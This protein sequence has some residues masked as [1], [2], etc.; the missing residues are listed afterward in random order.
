V[1]DLMVDL[2]TL[3]SKYGAVITQ[4]GACYFDRATG[5]IG[6]KFQVNIDAEDSVKEGFLIESGAVKFW[7]DQKHRTWLNP[8][9]VSLKDGL[10]QYR[11]F[12]KKADCVWSHATFDFSM[13]L[14]T[15][16]KLGIKPVNRY[17]T[18]R[19]IRTL[20]DLAKTQ[21]D[22]DVYPEDAHDAL[23]DCIRQVGYCYK[24]FLLLR[25][26]TDSLGQ[27]GR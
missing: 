12:S 8:P 13:L 1:K 14:A 26:P 3:G 10:D 4:I 2:E 27:Q 5:E 19:D 24:S 25:Q 18:T 20:V 11:Q 16:F 15:C 21:K 9:L 17:T 22:D 23:A 7:F 6:E